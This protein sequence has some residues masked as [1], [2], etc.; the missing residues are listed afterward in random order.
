MNPG[1]LLEL[2]PDM[3]A[4]MSSLS[5]MVCVHERERA[6]AR[7]RKRE[8]ERK[9]ERECD[10]EG[11]HVRQ[12]ESARAGA[13][14]L[15]LALLLSHL[16]SRSWVRFCSLSFRCWARALSLSRSRFLAR[17]LFLFLRYTCKYTLWQ[18]SS[19]TNY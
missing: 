15:S 7:K 17:S 19:Q 1:R 11:A 6:R 4:T 12:R 18:K 3:A 9:R 13:L 16:F 10:R 5:D 2:N 14:A 8:K